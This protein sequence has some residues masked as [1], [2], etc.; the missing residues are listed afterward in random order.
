MEH[1]R[2]STEARLPK[3]RPS[4]EP[5]AKERPFQYASVVEDGPL[6][7]NI[8]DSRN[9]KRATQHSWM[10]EA[11]PGKNFV[12]GSK[13]NFEATDNFA[14]PTK[15]KPRGERRSASTPRDLQDA[16][17]DTEKVDVF[18]EHIFFTQDVVKEVGSVNDAASKQEYRRAA[19]SASVPRNVQESTLQ[20]RSIVNDKPS[21]SRQAAVSS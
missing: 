4:E 3:K 19:R 14:L 5:A 9:V 7:E 10:M 18:G 15:Q 11:T 8:S 2:A 12:A 21:V 1:V 6:S 17:P 20:S 16:S 13:D